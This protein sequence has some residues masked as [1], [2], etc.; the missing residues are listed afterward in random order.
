MAR[1]AQKLELTEGVLEWIEAWD[2][3]DAKGAVSMLNLL[4]FKE[5]MHGEYLKYGKAFG[6]SIGRRRGGV[7]KVVGR[8]VG[9]QGEGEGWDEVALAHYPSI[10][11][12][13]D[14]AGSEDYQE[15][16]HRYRVGSL[17]DTCI[18]CTSELEL[19]D[20]EEGG[21]SGRAKL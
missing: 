14:M 9:G 15:V 8:V 2:P 16:N 13:A 17:R 18:L 10:R 7:A 6:E 11:H 21:G 5:G 12:F 19:P 1:S 3:E 20:V 4:A